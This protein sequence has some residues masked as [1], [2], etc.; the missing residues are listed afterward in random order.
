M[1]VPYRLG[2]NKFLSTVLPVC[3]YLDLERQG[4]AF[5]SNNMSISLLIYFLA[6]QYHCKFTGEL[7]LKTERISIFTS[8]MPPVE[9]SKGLLIPK[10]TAP[11]KNPVDSPSVVTA[12]SPFG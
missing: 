3:F 4:Q 12:V 1:Q 2:Q 7:N 6:V 8:W 11:S 10:I 9:Q 5:N